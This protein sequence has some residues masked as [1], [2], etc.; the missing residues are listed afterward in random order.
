MELWRYF[1]ATIH[2]CVVIASIC[3]TWHNLDD[4]VVAQDACP[5]TSYA[6][7]NL[8]KTSRT[9][10]RN[11][12]DWRQHDKA[13]V[14]QHVDRQYGSIAPLRLHKAFGD[15]TSIVSDKKPGRFF[16]ICAYAHAQ[17]DFLAIAA[18]VA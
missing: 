18:Y 12:R 6:Y 2:S 14:V 11:Y 13:S 4:S 9:T 16:K 5:D 8:R 10:S 15:K 17:I 3:Y 1:R 7:Q